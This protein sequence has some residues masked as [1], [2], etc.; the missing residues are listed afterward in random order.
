MTGEWAKK[1]VRA[2]QRQ[3]RDVTEIG[4]K[5]GERGPR[6]LTTLVIWIEHRCLHAGIVPGSVASVT[7]EHILVGLP[8]D[9]AHLAVTTLPWVRDH[10]FGHAVVEAKAAKVA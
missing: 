2:E 1:Y 9:I 6:V 3:F 4:C 8:A 5:S 7:Q 10:L